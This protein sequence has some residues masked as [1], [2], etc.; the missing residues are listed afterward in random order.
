MKHLVLVGACY[1]DTILTY[2]VVRL[3]HNKKKKIAYAL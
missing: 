1:L 3:L 2:V